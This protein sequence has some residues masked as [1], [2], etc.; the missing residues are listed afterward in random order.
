MKDVSPDGALE[1]S[2][3]K[4]SLR[5]LYASALLTAIILAIQPQELAALWR[6][7][8]NQERAFAPPQPFTLPS[9]PTGGWC[10]K[11]EPVDFTV[12][13]PRAAAARRRVCVSLFGW[14]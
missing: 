4:L 14:R 13:A 11:G 7:C 6:G 8:S 9:L 10:Y 1:L 12:E 2:P 5:Y 3:R